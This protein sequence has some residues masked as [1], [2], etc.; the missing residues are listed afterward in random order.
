MRPYGGFPHHLQRARGEVPCPKVLEGA[1]EMSLSSAG[2][3]PRPAAVGADA[4]ASQ[5]SALKRV[6]EGDRDVKQEQPAPIAA[7]ECDG[8]CGGSGATGPASEDEASE[9]GDSDGQEAWG[10][11]G[12][13][14]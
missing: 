1:F 12:R 8:D 4:A 14:G 7:M 10:R 5:S 9:S 3:P 6:R 2:A 11:V 13:R